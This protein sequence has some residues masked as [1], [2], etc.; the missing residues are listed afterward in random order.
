MYEEL[1]KLAA[2]RL[3]RKARA[4]AAGDGVVHEA[5]LR[6]VG[7]SRSGEAS[8][9]QIGTAGGIS[10]ERQQRRCGGFGRASSPER[11]HQRGGQQNQMDLTDV[12]AAEAGPAIDVLA[13]D[14]ALTELPRVDRGP[15]NW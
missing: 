15:R 14:Q 9:L 6:L 7:S 1:R 11:R 3:A 13:L 10:L 4:D 2:A 8:E 5:Y 12:P